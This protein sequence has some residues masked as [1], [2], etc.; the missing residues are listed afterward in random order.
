MR[1]ERRPKQ[2]YDTVALFHETE[3]LLKSADPQQV[4]QIVLQ[5]LQQSNGRVE[6]HVH[7]T[8]SVIIDGNNNS[9]MGHTSFGDNSGI[10]GQISKL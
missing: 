8:N 7:F 1:N 6:L 2:G 10:D 5:L 9:I 4:P 3:A